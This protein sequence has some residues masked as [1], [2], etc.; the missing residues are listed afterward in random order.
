MSGYLTNYKVAQTYGVTPV[1]VQ[2]W[3]EK[4]AKKKIVLE[5]GEHEGRIKIADTNENHQKLMV[6]A[7]NAAKFDQFRKVEMRVVIQD[8][9]YNYFSEDELF[10]II[11]GLR[12]SEIP[13]KYAFL[14]EGEEL[15]HNFYS[16]TAN[17]N[18]MISGY[19]FI[20]ESQF[21][22]VLERFKN[23]EGQYSKINVVDLGSGNGDPVIPILA[24]LHEK[25]L[26]H[27]YV[28]IDISQPLLERI[29]QN[30]HE[31][32]L[33]ELVIQEQVKK[34]CCDF[35][36]GL[37]VKELTRLSMGKDEVIPTLFIAF[38]GQLQNNEEYEQ[39]HILNNIRQVMNREQDRLFVINTKFNKNVVPNYSAFE[40]SELY[41][42]LTWLPKSLGINED[43]FTPHF[44][45]DEKQRKRSVGLKLNRALEIDFK[46][47]NISVKLKKDQVINIWKHRR[48]DYES[49]CETANKAQMQVSLFAEH[50]SNTVIGY[51]LR[52]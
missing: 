28:A 4:A 41:D 27:K 45:Y 19:Q 13:F 22:Y 50:P 26:L 8:D 7:N 21:D 52:I 39:L 38:G 49:V 35:D 44:D 29:N 36:N 1:T 23:E 18:T 25:D 16:A 33:G 17:T 12:N 9:L 37:P 32:G 10:Q 11:K 20:I 47:L 43:Y 40:K 3:V 24:R 46:K 30:L 6:L 14:G 2:K 42:F 51:L 15:W 31:H 34:I 48:E 5:V